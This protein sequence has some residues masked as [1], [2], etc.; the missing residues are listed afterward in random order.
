MSHSQPLLPGCGMLP[1]APDLHLPGGRLL[2]SE[3]PLLP[4]GSVPWPCRGGATHQV[5]TCPPGDYLYLG[6]TLSLASKL[7][8]PSLFDIRQNVALYGVLRLGERP[9]GG[10]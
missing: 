2:P 5:A 9:W 10:K 4:G 1:K 8:M 3:V 7:P 6:S